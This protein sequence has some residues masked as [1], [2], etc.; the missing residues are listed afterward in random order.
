MGVL[1]L[2]PRYRKPSWGYY[3]TV[4]GTVSSLYNRKD[5]LPESC[6]CIYIY[7]DVTYIYIYIYIEREREKRPQTQAPTSRNPN[8]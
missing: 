4:H 2:G 7:I 5:Q 6:V 3:I 8:P 1:A